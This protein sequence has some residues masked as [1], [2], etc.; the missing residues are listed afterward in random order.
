MPSA[1]PAAALAAIVD[2]AL[3][4]QAVLFRCHQVACGMDLEI[5][6]VELSRLIGLTA[7]FKGAH[8][9]DHAQGAFSISSVAL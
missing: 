6:L 1:N 8:C 5:F 7:L 2:G 9:A 3:P 4:A